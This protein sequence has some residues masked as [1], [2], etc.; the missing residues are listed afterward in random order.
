DRVSFDIQFRPT[1][2]LQSNAQLTFPYIETLSGGPPTFAP[3]FVNGAISLALQGTAPSFVLSYVLRSEQNVVTLPS[4]G[5]IVFPAT[6]V[7]LASQVTFSI[8]NRGS[9]PG[10]INAI[11]ITG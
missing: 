8:T 4:G 3:T 6:P 5:S 10:T 1:S 2:A 9:G 11:S 7:N